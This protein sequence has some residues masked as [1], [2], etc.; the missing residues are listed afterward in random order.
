MLADLDLGTRTLACAQK[1][2]S[3]N[4]KSPAGIAGRRALPQAAA[5]WLN[6]LP[7]SSE[8]EPCARLYEHGDG[9]ASL[10]ALIKSARPVQQTLLL[11]ACLDRVES[12]CDPLSATAADANSD[13]NAAAA[14]TAQD[15]LDHLCGSGAL[16]H[17]GAAA[18]MLT[19]T[20]A[21]GEH[22]AEL[23]CNI[24]LI[25][26]AGASANPAAFQKI[27]KPLADII[28]D[29]KLALCAAVTAAAAQSLFPGDGGLHLFTAQHGLL[30][31]YFFICGA[32]AGAGY[33]SSSGNG[34]FPTIST[35]LTAAL[36][37]SKLELNP[38]AL[39]AD[40]DPE[41]DQTATTASVAASAADEAAAAADEENEAELN[42]TQM[43]PRL[44]RCGSL[45]GLPPELMHLAFTLE[46]D[47]LSPAAL[48]AALQQLAAS[49]LQQAAELTAGR[50]CRGLSLSPDQLPEITAEVLS[51]PQLLQQLRP[52][53]PKK[54]GQDGGDDGDDDNYDESGFEARERKAG[55]YPARALRA[56]NKAKTGS[57]DFSTRVTKAAEAAAAVQAVF[58]TPAAGAAETSGEEGQEGKGAGKWQDE[59][60]AE[61]EALFLGRLVA[62]GALQLQLPR[63]LLICGLS[64]RYA[65]PQGLLPEQAGD[66][67]LLQRFDKVLQEL[68]QRC[69]CSMDTAAG[70]RANMLNFLRPLGTDRALPEL[71]EE[72]PFLGDI[73][74]IF[75]FACPAVTFSMEGG[76]TA[77][78]EEYV[79]AAALRAL[80]LFILLLLDSFAPQERKER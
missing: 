23:P 44:R 19:I 58:G 74:E 80:P 21:L 52:P 11:A 6:A 75:N 49:S 76:R 67:L 40:A 20:A 62:R 69:G 26:P 77:Q 71:A 63:P 37:I 48:S 78:G 66:R 47:E 54:P 39:A 36:L 46:P 65:P 55:T 79:S 7:G 56:F 5:A 10:L 73:R 29:E 43:L 15:A 68:N 59:A 18:C 38:A 13:S 30:E 4:Q 57:N 31:P 70:G 16:S 51:L 41:Q 50:I 3:L 33:S 14:P 34:T 32:E 61:A 53:K 22:R 27:A 25:C 1:L 2:I 17:L 42:N 64:S 12:A 24:L 28:V 8:N 60:E 35:P 45:P 72:N 9:S